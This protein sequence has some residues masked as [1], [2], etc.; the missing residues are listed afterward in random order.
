MYSDPES[1]TDYAKWAQ[2]S[3]PVARRVRDQF[4]PKENA[5]PDKIVGLDLATVDAI[6]FKY[7]TKPLTPEQL[8]EL[9]QLQEPIR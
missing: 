9:I 5:L 4:V 2:V 6:A 7:L 3:E 8:K 1:L